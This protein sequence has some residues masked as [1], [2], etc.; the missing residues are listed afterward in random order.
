[1]NYETVPY[2]LNRIQYAKPHV[3]EN[4]FILYPIPRLD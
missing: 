3:P 4:Y 2:D 1:M